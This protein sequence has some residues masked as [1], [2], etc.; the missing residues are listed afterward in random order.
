M[1]TRPHTRSRARRLLAVG[2]SLSVIAG[3]AIGAGGL[4]L[5]QIETQRAEVRELEAQLIRVESQASQAAGAHAQAQERVGELR[6]EISENSRRIKQARKARAVAQ[7]RLADRLVAL[8]TEPQPTFVQ[9]LLTSGDLGS[10][11]E[12]QE[13]LETIGL[14]DRGIIRSARESRRRLA[15]ARTRLVSARAEAQETARQQQAELQRLNGLLLQRR[16]FLSQSRARLAGLVA[17]EEQ[18]RAQAA[19]IAAVQSEG[20]ADLRRQAAGGAPA[21]PPAPAAPAPA[22]GGVN[23]HLARIARCESGGNPT[24]VSSSGQYRGK[25]QFDQQTWEAVGGSGDPAS[26]PE[27]EQDR[28]AAILY[29]QRGW[30]PWPVCGRT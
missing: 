15:G 1:S 12:A 23:A 29:N 6:E 25:Y 4:A 3:A 7:D 22:G 14:A 18:R 27:A 8:Y 17:A 10:V 19:A 5:G 13:S 30:H 20:E 2:A 28:R 16:G 21:P 9:L 26:A 11:V 24:I